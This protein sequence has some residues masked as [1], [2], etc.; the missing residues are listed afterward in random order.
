MY[1][2][3][4]AV[5]RGGWAVN[6]AEVLL[7]RLERVKPRGPH[8]WS[9]SC[10]GPLHERGDR[11]GGLGIKQVNDRVLINCPAGCSAAEIVAAVGLSLGDLFERPLTSTAASPVR[12]PP[13]PNAM[14]DRV[15]RAATVLLLAA[16]QLRYAKALTDADFATVQMAYAEID[17]IV[18]Q[19]ATWPRA[20]GS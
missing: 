11:S 15:F 10:P 16:D 19:A 7:E 18:T 9:A 8:R 5:D 17:A 2:D 14:A 3:H 4:A 20:V 6:A 12:Q 1:G 13:F